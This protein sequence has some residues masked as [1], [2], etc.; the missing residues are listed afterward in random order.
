MRIAYIILAHKQPRQLRRLVTRLNAPG[1]TFYVHVDK[2]IGR[3]PFRQFVSALDGC[4]NVEFVKR[5]SSRWGEF[6]LVRATLEGIATALRRQPPAGYVVF[7]SG[8]DYPIKTPAFIDDF[9]ERNQGR[10]FLDYNPV[11]CDEWPMA[12]YRLEHWYVRTMGKVLVLPDRE[13]GL[14]LL[15]SPRKWPVSLLSCCLPRTR[16]FL[17][18]YKP[19]TG[20][21]FWALS[22]AAA[23]YIDDFVRREPSFVRFFRFTWVADELFFQTLLLNSPLADQVED[24]NLHYMAW[25]AG[26]AHPPVLTAADLDKIAG[27]PALF[28]RKFDIEIDERIL[29]LIDGLPETTSRTGKEKENPP[30]SRAC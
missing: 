9:L 14:A 21:A 29:G 8:Q 11:P 4:D 2:S 3:A 12:A 6:G 24:S 23:E 25:S 5:Y 27:S 22:R 30:S 17:K 19:F 20:S 10:S 26:D 16:P 15:R 13:G 18:G 1:V 28:A 7:L